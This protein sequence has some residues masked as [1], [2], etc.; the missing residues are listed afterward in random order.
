MRWFWQRRKKD[1]TSAV[2][3]AEQAKQRTPRADVPR[4]RRLTAPLALAAEPR[5]ALLTFARD[6]LNAQGARVRV[7]EDD[8]VI[9][10]LPDGG[11]TRYTTSLARA[12]AE[13]ETTLLTQ[14]AP[15]LETL[16][17]EAASRARVASAVLAR[18]DDAAT[19]A[20]RA[21]TPPAEACGRCA[22]DGHERWQAGIPTCDACPLRHDAL[23]L[24]WES[25][26][27]VVGVLR[28][29]EEPSV[30]LTYRITGRDRRGRRDEWLRVA[31]DTRTGAHLAP[32]TLER[33]GS[34]Q[35]ASAV[36]NTMVGA[37]TASGRAR[38]T[39]RPSLEALS[40]YLVQRVGTEF[41]R[42]IADLTTTHERL[43]RERPDDAHVIAAALDRELASLAEVYGVEVDATLEA[44]VLITSPMAFVTTETANGAGPTVTIDAGRGV[45]QA[46]V[47]MTCGAAARAGRV[48]A[49]GHVYCA[50]CAETCAHCDVVR[51]LAC[52]EP[53]LAPCGLCQEPACSTCARMCDACGGRFCPDHVWM[54]VEGDQTLCLRDLTLCG[55]CQRPL[56]QTHAASC[57]VCG[58]ALCPRHTRACA[59]GGEALCAKHSTAC[60][61]CHHALCGAHVTHCE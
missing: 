2:D 10:T 36:T 11:M 55:E 53:P 49:H 47:C 8:L 50:T 57:S 5:D 60:A 4:A 26:P 59:T 14:G 27:T 40:A 33:L 18:G 22:G 15:A 37:V 7:E 39:L 54:C 29:E 13:G 30:E 46:P 19:L 42:R 20:T 21:I 1:A 16:F 34:A 43:K 31:F 58:E 41:Q 48:C 28:W 12:R 25:P 35:R 45:A 52:A 56:C 3:T 38:E 6:L 51:C 44:V 61:S 23:A 24:R 32:L 17:E 9:A